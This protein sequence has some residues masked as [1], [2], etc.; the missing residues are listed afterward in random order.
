LRK[1]A[2]FI[3]LNTFFILFPVYGHWQGSLAG[4]VGLSHLKGFSQIPQGGSDNTTSFQR[5]NFDE[6][7]IDH[8]TFYE[9]SAHVGFDGYYAQ[10]IYR[11]LHPNGD[12]VLTEDLRTH[13]KFI[14][15][16]EHF[17]MQTQ[18]R[19]WTFGLGWNYQATSRFTVTPVFNGNY[20]N[21]HYGYSS[22][23]ASS[24]RDFDLLALTAGVNLT[25]Q[26]KAH[27]Y[28]Q[29][30]SEVTIPL[31]CLR[32]Y[33]IAFR[34]EPWICLNKHLNLVPK[35][36]LG[37]FRIDYQDNQA[38]PNHIRYAAQPYGMMTLSLNFH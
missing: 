13:A 28:T 33:K 6:L 38:V 16:G 12:A 22:L 2:S 1:L 3:A 36:D 27:L 11:N 26:L 18:Y 34:L 20:F 14:P 29:L 23:Q 32:I 15:S 35:I 21:Y 19:W 4:G 31:S 25:Y 17:T 10:F 7:A 24:H 37:W 8:E 9:L 5:P 30:Q